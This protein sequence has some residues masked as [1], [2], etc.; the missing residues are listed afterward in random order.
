LAAWW[1]EMMAK[2]MYVMVKC[3]GRIDAR[4]FGKFKSY[5]VLAPLSIFRSTEGWKSE[6]KRVRMWFNGKGSQM[7]V[8]NGIFTEIKRKYPK[9]ADVWEPIEAEFEGN[10]LLIPKGWDRLLTML[11]K[12]YMQLPK[13]DELH[14]HGFVDNVEVK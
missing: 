9:G 3:R 11:Y 4:K 8:Y 13:A 12:D 14:V 6:Y 5:F 2:L 1:K 7:Q 10:W